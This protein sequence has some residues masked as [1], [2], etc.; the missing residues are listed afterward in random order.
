[1]SRT[2]CETLRSQYFDFSKATCQPCQSKQPYQ[3]QRTVAVWLLG[4]EGACHH[5]PSRSNVRLNYTTS[6][7]DRTHPRKRCVHPQKDFTVQDSRFYG[8]PAL[9]GL[10]FDIW[11]LL[12]QL[13]PPGH[14]GILLASSVW[15]ALHAKSRL[16]K[17]P[18]IQLALWH[19][20]ESTLVRCEINMW[21]TYI[22]IYIYVCIL[23]CIYIYNY[24]Y[25]YIYTYM[26]IYIIYIYIKSTLDP[27]AVIY[28]IYIYTHIKST[29]DSSAVLERYPVPSQLTSPN[30]VVQGWHSRH[31]GM[32]IKSWACSL[33]LGSLNGLKRAWHLWQIQL[34]HRAPCPIIQ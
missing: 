31:D 21:Y 33:R 10:S 17:W 23:I 18:C 25:I 5:V 28:I 30:V 13:P 11:A 34:G 24:I 4:G 3:P 22:L 27:S 7:R 29:L 2:A 32:V 14:C 8:L 6:R 19:C 16:P 1:M 12:Y 26:S 15:D 20:G 9:P